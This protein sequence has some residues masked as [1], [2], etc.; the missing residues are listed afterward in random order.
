[1]GERVAAI[2][3]HHQDLW[4]SVHTAAARLLIN[5]AITL[6]LPNDFFAAG[7]LFHKKQVLAHH[8]M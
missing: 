3:R 5:T 1:M 4:Q 6:A 7:N 2:T 8:L